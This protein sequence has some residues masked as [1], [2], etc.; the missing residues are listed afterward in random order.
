MN[1]NRNPRIK[2]ATEIRTFT[3]L[4]DINGEFMGRLMVTLESLYPHDF[5]TKRQR[6]F[7]EHYAD[8]VEYMDGDCDSDR[9][10]YRFEQ[11]RNA[12]PYINADLAEDILKHF[13][14]PANKG[15]FKHPDYRTAFRENIMLMLYTLHED[16]GFGEKR[17]AQTAQA[18]KACEYPDPLAYMAQLIGAEFS[19]NSDKF[20]LEILDRRAYRK[21]RHATL[22][23]EI[24]SVKKLEEY[25]KYMD[26]L[27]GA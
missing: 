19:E 8:S 18:W 24:D 21:Q 16:F 7:V 6:K 4:S 12:A 10:L 20:A 11:L 14:T 13:E 5:Y 22:R 17:I 25:R 15:F 23:E 3:R 27:N 1:V 26:K 9:R 2:R